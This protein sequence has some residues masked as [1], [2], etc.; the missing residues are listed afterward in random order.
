ML[1]TGLLLIVGS[2]AACSSSSGSAPTDGGA[3][4]VAGD[5]S[6][7]NDSRESGADTDGGAADVA[8]DGSSI[9]DSR[10]SGA[11]VAGDGSSN[12][13]SGESGTD[14]GSENE[15]TGADSG[16]A[17]DGGPVT[18]ASGFSS[19]VAIAVDSTSVYWTTSTETETDGTF[20]VNSAVM[21]V[22]LGGGTPTTLATGQDFLG[23]IAVNATGVYWTD[24][25]PST[26]E[27]V[28]VMSV[29]LGGGTPTALASALYLNEDIAVDSTNVYWT[30]ANAQAVMSVPVGGGTPITLASGQVSGLH[31][32]GSNV[33]PNGPIAVDSTHVYWTNSA[34]TAGDTLMSVPIGGGTPT[35]LATGLTG[36]VDLVVDAT[37]VY[38]LDQS[39]QSVMKVALGGGT[40]ITLYTTGTAGGISQQLGCSFNQFDLA[41]DSTSVYFLGCGEGDVL[42]VPIG[43]GTP[44]TL[45]SYQTLATAIAVTATSLYWFDGA[46]QGLVPSNGQLMALTPK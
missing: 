21:K 4:D 18:L 16:A 43:G 22:P 37:S 35:T 25:G 10:E 20:M 38:W 44:T 2:L 15:D 3:A 42:S 14:S 9:N 34:F 5:G 41:L 29:P 40:P 26:T 31:V 28:S 13:D 30:D 6:S 12:N 19:P 32:P 45:A 27:I 17:T 39:T 36:P 24:L 8:G 1:R 46:Q 11:D 33:A 23:G 7:I